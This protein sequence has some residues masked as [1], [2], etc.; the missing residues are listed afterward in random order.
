MTRANQ[1]SGRAYLTNGRAIGGSAIPDS[2][3]Q[4]FDAREESTGSIT[5]ATDQ[6]GL[7]DLT[8][9]AKVLT[10][11]DSNAINSQQTYYWDGSTEMDHDT[12]ITTAEPFAII[13]VGYI[14]SIDQNGFLVDGGS[15]VEFAL[16]DN[17]G[18]GYGLYRGTNGTFPSTIEF[19]TNVHI[20]TLIGENTDDIRWRIDSVDINTASQDASDLTGLTVSDRAGGGNNEEQYI[21]QLEVL[22]QPSGQDIS[23]VE[24]RLANEWGVSI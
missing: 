21:G 24:S 19:D 4:Q 5:T 3:V 15:D 11:G 17:S 1:I 18:D 2:V 16:L 7:A 10:S 20:Y 12:S 14:P 13:W 22:D 6:L 9:N 8:G 23:D